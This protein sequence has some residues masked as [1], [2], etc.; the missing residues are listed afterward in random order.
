VLQWLPV[1]CARTGRELEI[2]S[3]TQKEDQCGHPPPFFI[4]RESC[5]QAVLEIVILSSDCCVLRSRVIGIKLVELKFNRSCMTIDLS[6][7][8]SNDASDVPN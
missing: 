8:R 6:T 4:W 7:R 1:R 3:Q 2:E 5:Q